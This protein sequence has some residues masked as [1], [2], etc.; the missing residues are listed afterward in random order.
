M[1]EKIKNLFEIGKRFESLFYQIKNLRE[2]LE[3]EGKSREDI[4]GNKFLSSIVA[5]KVSLWEEINKIT[6]SIKIPG[7]YILK[8]SFPE[9]PKPKKFCLIFE[10]RENNTSLGTLGNG[11]GI[12]LGM[13]SSK[14]LYS[15]KEVS[16]WIKN[17]IERKNNNKMN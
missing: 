4:I 11:L 7:K 3:S 6:D 8:A 13:R 1:N 5:E 14:N 15:I 10:W 2:S 17:N 12:D 16:D 9:Y